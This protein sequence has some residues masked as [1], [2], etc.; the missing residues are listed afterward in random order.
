MWN[1]PP[2]LA[3]ELS[4]LPL[5]NCLYD[6]E[7]IFPSLPDFLQGCDHTIM[8]RSNWSVHPEEAGLEKLRQAVTIFV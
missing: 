4:T 2:E 7:T 3:G 6:V 8:S 5:P 1:Q